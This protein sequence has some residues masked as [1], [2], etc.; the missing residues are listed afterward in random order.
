MLLTSYLLSCQE[1]RPINH[2]VSQLIRG[3][4]REYN[5]NYF[6]E[7][8][9]YYDIVFGTMT[10]LL[11]KEQFLASRGDAWAADC[12]LILVNDCVFFFYKIWDF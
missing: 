8:L 11:K 12:S 3:P 1:K 6:G 5:V 10:Y 2:R 9:I 4:P 7:L